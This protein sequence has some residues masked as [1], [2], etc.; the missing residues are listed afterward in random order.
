MRLCLI[1]FIGILCSCSTRNYEIKSPDKNIALNFYI[2]NNGVPYYYVIFKNDT[3]I[4]PSL[5]GV[6]FTDNRMDTLLSLEK[7]KISEGIISYDY[8]KEQYF[9][10]DCEYNAIDALVSKGRQKLN[11]H[12]RVYDDGIALRYFAHGFENTLLVGDMTEVNFNSQSNTT[13]AMGENIYNRYIGE[14]SQD[15]KAPKPLFL[16]GDS[17]ACPISYVKMPVIINGYNGN[18][19]SLHV[20][21]LDKELGQ[22]EFW[23]RKCNRR[24]SIF[25]SMIKKGEEERIITLPS[26]SP[27]MVLSIADSPENLIESSID[28][29]L[30]LEEEDPILSREYPLNIYKTVAF[31]NILKL[32]KLRRSTMAHDLALSVIFNKE[33]DLYDGNGEVFNLYPTL[34]LRKNSNHAV[35]FVNSIPIHW[36]LMKTVDAEFGQYIIA[37]RKDMDSDNWFLG[38]ATNNE[39]RKGSISLDFLKENNLYEATLY[40]DD[41]NSNRDLDPDALKVEKLYVCSTDSIHFNMRSNGGFSMSIVHL[42][43]GLE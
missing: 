37:A 34:L 33:V 29:S 6:K 25:T 19:M 26:Y 23:L 24:N 10:H 11:I 39:A 1:A 40:S 14:D 13:W 22:E 43:P 3:V 38:G 31:G 8:T 17:T 15:I 42:K 18:Y 28:Y 12:M 5:L 21:S 41:I 16:N 27:W 4:K 30:R 7:V 36:G 9:S 35:D 20:F 2:D 32:N